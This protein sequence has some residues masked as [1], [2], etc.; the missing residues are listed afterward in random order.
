VSRQRVPE[1]V[2]GVAA[3]GE[4]MAQPGKAKAHRFESLIRK[5]LSNT[6]DM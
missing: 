2:S 4:H 6:S 5:L 3:I 1:L